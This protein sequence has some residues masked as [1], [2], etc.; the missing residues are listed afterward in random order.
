MIE[1][2]KDLVAAM[3]K[4]K[5][6]LGA[7]VPLRELPSSVTNDELLDAIKASIDSNVNLLPEKFGY[8]K[9]DNDK[10]ILI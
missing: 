5:E 2:N 6:T 7:T 4:F 9:L 1:M 3:K 8:G 10:N